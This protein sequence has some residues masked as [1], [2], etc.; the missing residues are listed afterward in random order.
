MMRVLWFSNTPANGEYYLNKRVLGGGWLSSLDKALQDQAYVELSVAF[1]H[2]N[3]T[4]PFIHEGTRYYPI[5]SRNVNTRWKK[6]LSRFTQPQ[7][8]QQDLSLYMT[9]IEQVKPDIIHIHGTENPFACLIPNVDV[10]VLVSMQGIVSIYYHK[11][12]CGIERRYLNVSR[13]N[14]WKHLFFPE[15]FKR[16]YAMFKK[17]S[18][19]EQRLFSNIQYVMGR[20]DWDRR[21]TRILAPTSYY[22]HGEELLRNA[23]Y[24]A[25]WRMPENKKKLIVHT[26]S[27][28]TFYKGFETVCQTLYLL[29]QIGINIEWRVAGIARDDLINKVVKKV[30]GEKYPLTNLVLLGKLNPDTLLEKIKEAHIYVMPS[31]IENSPNSLCEAMMLGMPCVA[32]FSG[33]TGSL[34][35]DGTEGILIQDGDPWSM[36]GAVLELANNTSRAEKLGI[37]ARKRALQRHDKST[38]V[39]NLVKTYQKMISM[40]KGERIIS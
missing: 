22:F 11:Y 27:G 29:N 15:K 37:N 33:G 1:Y 34:L 6:L 8:T 31:H 17:M 14:S 28:N 7:V 23:F 21:V 38:I 39:E 20:T 16:H 26:T 18:N 40:H 24:Q 2:N 36:A 9:I 25:V 12:L 4:E 5:H 30:L 13:L 35:K 32:A 3:K 10:P 19:R